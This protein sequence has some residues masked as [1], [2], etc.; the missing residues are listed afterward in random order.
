METAV[1]QIWLDYDELGALLGCDAA[2]ARAAAAAIPLDRRKSRDGRTR[3]KLDAVLVARFLDRL[4]EHQID[5]RLRG[6]VA[7]LR[8]VHALMV[9]PVTPAT[10]PDRVSAAG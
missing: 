4:V 2:Q 6:C 9:T 5:E 3:A 8:A 7:D 10:T 1:P